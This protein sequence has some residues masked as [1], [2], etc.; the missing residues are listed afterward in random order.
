M[1]LINQKKSEDIFFGHTGKNFAGPYAKLNI[2]KKGIPNRKY[3]LD[4]IKN[5]VLGPNR[6]Y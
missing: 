1:V 4:S 2:E 6:Q 3:S 5:T